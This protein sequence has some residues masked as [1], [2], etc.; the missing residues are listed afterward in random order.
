[1]QVTTALQI[2]KLLRNGREQ[3]GKLNAGKIIE[4]EFYKQ[5]LVN[6]M[7]IED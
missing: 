6:F 4:K 7:E 1:M 3:L 5:L 2:E